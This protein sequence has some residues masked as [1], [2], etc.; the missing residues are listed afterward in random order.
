MVAV[1]CF[2]PGRTKYLPAPP[3]KYPARLV[4][5]L[6]STAAVQQNIRVGAVGRRSFFSG[7]IGVFFFDIMQIPR[8][9]TAPTCTTPGYR[10]AKYFPQ[11]THVDLVFEIATC[12]DKY[13][14]YN[15][16]GK[17][18]KSIQNLV[19]KAVKGGGRREGSER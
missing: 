1:A 17:K 6:C 3:H 16:D 2:L 5:E 11:F 10:P 19:I 8:G 4:T 7:L 18:D 15:V 13:G 14:I 12:E 9:P